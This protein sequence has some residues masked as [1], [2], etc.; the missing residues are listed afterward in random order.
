MKVEDFR[1]AKWVVKPGASDYGCKVEEVFFGVER[2][3]MHCVGLR[4]IRI[5]WFWA[6]FFYMP[7]F[8]VLLAKERQLE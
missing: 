2:E 5:G 6:G 8:T 4:A 7:A 1:I 3:D